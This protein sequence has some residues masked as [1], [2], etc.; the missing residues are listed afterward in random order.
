MG[1][2]LIQ[3]THTAETC[4]SKNPEMVRQLASHVTVANAAK[5]GVTLLADF[6]N[7]QEH[8]V[9]L[10]LEASSPDK[11]VNFALPFLRV[12]SLTIK[13]GLTC[14]QVAQECLKA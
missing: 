7:E 3:H 12:G 4:P 6:V 11:A 9:V 1:L 2:Y 8:T 10:V 14:D 5:H 13:A